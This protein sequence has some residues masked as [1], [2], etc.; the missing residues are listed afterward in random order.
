[1]LFTSFFIVSLATRC[2][3]TPC[4]SRPSSQTCCN[5]STPACLDH[6]AYSVTMNMQSCTRGK[7]RTSRY[8]LLIGM[9]FDHL[10]RAP[11][12]TAGVLV[13]CCQDLFSS[14]C[15]PNI[16]KSEV[17]FNKNTGA[18]QVPTLVSSS[19]IPAAR[20]QSPVGVAHASTPEPFGVQQPCT[21]TLMATQS[22][23]HTTS[24]LLGT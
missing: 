2:A 14:C 24:R 15:S 20:N 5:P 17:Y 3:I 10:H 22:S 16:L 4:C 23:Q 1:M 8:N 11:R 18:N 9:L 6:T 13:L 12:I 21:E 7:Q 19:Q